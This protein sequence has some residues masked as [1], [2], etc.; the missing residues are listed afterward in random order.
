M[1]RVHLALSLATAVAITGCSKSTSSTSAGGGSG[2]SLPPGVT[3]QMV[4]EGDSI[5][6]NTTPQLSSCARC[7]GVKGVGA[8]NGPSLVTGAWLHSGG[9]YD[10]IVATIT[11]GVPQ[12]RIKDPARRFG[13]QPRGGQ[14][15]NLTDARIRSVA[16]YVY[17]I[18]RGKTKP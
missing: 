17:S 8:Q 5:Y 15:M 11:T 16:A 1:R 18:S 4:A 9:T 3:A 12:A 10:E 7:H 6:N 14:V 2:P 13:M